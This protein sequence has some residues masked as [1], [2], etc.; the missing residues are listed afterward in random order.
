MN[1]L[2]STTQILDVLVPLEGPDRARVLRAVQA[3]IDLTVE[4]PSPF[5]GIDIPV[6]D[7]LVVTVAKDADPKV[8]E[9]VIHAAV[10]KEKPARRAPKGS[11]L[12]VRILEAIRLGAAQPKTIAKTVG[13]NSQSYPFRK[14]LS[15]LLKSGAVT[16]TGSCGGRTYQAGKRP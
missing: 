13:A 6:R 14:A 9:A 11:E 2:A 10:E 12:E 4:P 8:A 1:I 3:A 15:K 5:A 7:A 16:A